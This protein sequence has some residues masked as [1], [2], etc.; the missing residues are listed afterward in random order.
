[1]SRGAKHKLLSKQT[2]SSDFTV[3]SD[4]EETELET[5]LME[6]FSKKGFTITYVGGNCFQLDSRQRQV[7]DYLVVGADNSYESVLRELMTRLKYT[8]DKA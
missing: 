8:R 3:Q 4:T 1:M 6:L 2:S 5:K 7:V